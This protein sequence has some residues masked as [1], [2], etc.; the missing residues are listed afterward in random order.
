MGASNND[1]NSVILR[2][3]IG[4]KIFNEAVEAKK[5]VTSDEIDSFKIEKESLRKKTQITP[6]DSKILDALQF[7]NIPDV[8]IKVYTTLMSLRNA[9]E[10]I[11]SKVMKIEEDTIKNILRKL[12]DRKWITATNGIYSAN[13]PTLVINDEINK[14]RYDF[15]EKIKKLKTE[16]LPSLET[17]YVQNN[18]A[19]QDENLD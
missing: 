4:V 11:L 1:W 19:R 6:I 17:V 12:K 13:N 18:H 5:I 9:S 3:N 14:V 15:F 10:S 2:T 16:V 8:E 7:L